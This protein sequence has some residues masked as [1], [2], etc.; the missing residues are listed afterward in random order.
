[1][2]R[3]SKHISLVM[4]LLFLFTMGG[5][6]VSAF[7]AWSCASSHERSSHHECCRCHCISYDYHTKSLADSCASHGTDDTQSEATLSA[8]S[9]KAFAKRV[10]TIIS[11]ICLLTLIGVC[12]TTSSRDYGE[13]RRVDYVQ[14]WIC[15]VGLLRAPPI[16]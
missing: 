7:E 2:E 5:R 6:A 16:C 3:T 4:L 10:F 14:E 12:H 11:A 8:E 13:L 1:M 15:S 9:K